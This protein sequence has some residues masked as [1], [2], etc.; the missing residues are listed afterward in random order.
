MGGAE[1]CEKPKPKLKSKTN[2]LNGTPCLYALLSLADNP[3]KAK[4][5]A[6]KDI[7]S[8]KSVVLTN[9]NDK[10]LEFGDIDQYPALEDDPSEGQ[11]L[12]FKCLQIGPEYTPQLTQYVG[13]LKHFDKNTKSAKFLVLFDENEGKSRLNKFEIDEVIEGKTMRNQEI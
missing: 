9:T 10:N 5:I 13:E 11:T 7:Y 6:Q 4:R 3:I 12:A 1:N 2:G 8:S